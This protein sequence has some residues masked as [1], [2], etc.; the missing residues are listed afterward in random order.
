[1]R[2]EGLSPRRGDAPVDGPDHRRADRHRDWCCR[3]CSCRWRSS[4]ARPASSTA[5]SRSRSFRRWCCRCWSRCAD[6]GAVRDAAASAGRQGRGS[7][8]AGLLRLRSTQC[9]DAATTRYRDRSRHIIGTCRAGYLAS[10]SAL[11]IAD[12]R[13]CSCGCRPRSCRTRIRACLIAMVQTAGRR[14]ASER[15]QHAARRST[16]YFLV[17]EKEA[18]DADVHDRGLELQRQRPERRH[19]LRCC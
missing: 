3:R 14:D 13:C 10:I 7:A 6:A 15:T 19:R 1:M 18:V 2:E 8:S 5:S 11:A 9:F 12:G 4:A 16:D 17:H